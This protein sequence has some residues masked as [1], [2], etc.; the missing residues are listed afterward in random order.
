[1]VMKA[2]LITNGFHVDEHKAGDYAIPKEA[3]GI[4]A[5]L[6]CGHFFYDFAGKWNYQNKQD[7]T[8]ITV[9][10]SIFC[11]GDGSKDCWH[12]YLTKGEWKAV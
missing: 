3:L 2:H 1:M 8:M 10:P 7:E 6:P 12:G 4:M 5:I 9:T 11:H